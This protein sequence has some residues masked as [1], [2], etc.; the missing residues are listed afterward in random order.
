M[1]NVKISGL[2]IGTPTSTSIF[3][4][5]DEGTT[6]QGAI[7]AITSNSTVEVTYDELYSLYTGGT[8]TSGRFYLMTDFQTCYDQPNYDYNGSAIQTG[9]YKTGTT[10][11]LL[12]LAISTTGFSS[13]VYSEL[14]PSDVITYDITWDT[15]E[16]T[17]SPAKGRITYRID[18]QGNAFDYDFREV[19]FKR[20]DAYFSEEVYNGTVSIDNEGIVTG[21][22]TS[23]ENFTVGNIVGIL[24]NQQQG[25]IVNYYEIVSISGDT[26]MVVTGN[27]II[28]SSNVR[29]VDA[30]VLSGM[31][32]KQ[33]NIISNTSSVELLTFGDIEQCFNNTST[34][35]AAYTIWQEDTFL[36]PN[37][38]FKGQNTYRE[39][40]FAQNFR[41]NTF[42]TSCDSNKVMGSFYNNIFNN[43]FDNNT[44]NDNF[45]DNIIDCDFTRNIVNGEFYD[46]HFGDVDG[47]DFDYNIINGQFYRN[48]FTGENDFEYNIIRGEFFQNIILDGFNKNTIN[49]FYDNVLEETFENNQIGEEF[50]DNTIYSSF[51]DNTIGVNFYTNTIYSS[52][53]SNT[54]GR[55]FNNNTLGDSLNTS[56]FEF[57]RNRIGEYFE[58]N[59]VRRYFQNNQIGNQFNNNTLNGDFYK[60]VIGNGFKDNYNI[61]H[62]FYGNH[63]GNDFNDNDVIGDY[64][65]DN[66]IGEYFQDN[67]NISY[68]FRN[69]QI[70]NEF[71]NNTLGNSDYF[72]W[73]NTSVEN[74]TVRTYDTFYNSLDG[75][76]SNIIGKELIMS[77]TS[78]S[79][80]TLNGGTLVIGDTYEIT[81]YVVGDDFT[82][83]ADVQSGNINENG[84]VFIATGEIP[85]VWNSGSELTELTIYD[86]Y[87]KVKFTEW[88]QGCCNGGF[89]YE[90]TKV[91]PS[92]ESTVY[93]TRTNSGQEIDVI[94]AG[95]L[96]IAR[97]SGGI[98][99][100]AK[101]GSFDS[102]VSPIDTDWNSIYTQN[103]NGNGFEDNIIGNEFK[104][105]LMLNNFLSN[106]VK[107]YVV[108][109]QFSGGVYSNQIGSYTLVNNFLGTVEGNIWVNSFYNNVI[110]LNFYNNTFRNNID[111]NTIANDFQNNEIGSSFNNN[112]IGD[113]FGFGFGDL[114]G[115]K[116]GNNFYENTVGEYFYNNSIPDNFYNNTIGDY[117]QWNVVNTNI[118][119]TDFTPNYGN[120][121]GFTYTA[122]GTSATDSLYTDINGTTNAL[123]VNAT[124]DIE[125]SG[126]A[127]I[128]V[129]G[130]TVGKLYVTGNTITILGAQIGGYSNAIDS[131]SDDGVGKN[132]SDGTYNDLSSTGGTGTNATFDVSVSSG[133]VDGVLINNRGN[134]Y[135]IGDELTIVGSLFGG[136]DGVDDITITVTVLFNDDVV[137]T[138]SGVTIPSVY[139]TYTCQIFERQGGVKRLSFYDDNDILTITNINE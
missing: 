63:I 73:D 96:E 15:T 94:V 40:S 139:E 88:W 55:Y 93:F 12:L 83:V 21:T 16:V 54:I 130:N 82:D 25:E 38:V 138:V 68:Y 129:S 33:N 1:V 51:Y 3:P 19:L 45:Y 5:V 108:G 112:I 92:V 42:N 123:G 65:Q 107:S 103:N 20:Y 62:D 23:F 58:Y 49:G 11:P 64:F 105:N 102:N 17:N 41:N 57:Y 69:N 117:F 39:N 136:T 84:C 22:N 80:T 111:N 90:R 87:H 47:G 131:I 18:N 133:L 114:Q 53:Y 76:Y 35:T 61:G 137:I 70:G 67:N 127:V 91:Y 135:E 24:N 97:E 132:G 66:Q 72:N 115:N 106:N 34:N 8:L 52:F 78:N 118:N 128:G 116:I 122:T 81:N 46:N 37:N 113:N 13:T 29:L 4:F 124:F 26:D 43:D 2:P 100:A 56:N 125:V 44:I 75:N 32:W 101:E 10:E 79:G 7:S 104:G 89:S 120:I 59:N 14:H 110:G 99:N 109:N 9:N 27:T 77:F 28:S 60:N 95:R 48:F 71:D 126:G 86:E 36:L 98:Y 31:S 85:A 119:T 30:N 134:G 121:T 50:Y 6:Y 74:L